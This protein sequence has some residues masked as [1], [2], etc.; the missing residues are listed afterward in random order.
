MIYDCHLHTSFSADCEVSPEIMIEQGIKNGL[1][2]ICMTDHQDEDF[3][4]EKVQF[5][6]DLPAYY[7][8]YQ[9]LQA[10]YEKDLELLF[11]VELG[12][13][14]HL[15]ENLASYVKSAPFDFVI[16]SIHLINR[17]DPW[18][19]DYFEGRDDHSA[20]TEYFEVA[21]ENVKSFQDFDAFGHLDYIIRYS[22][23]KN[24]NYSYATYRDFIDEILKILVHKGIGLELNTGSIKSG[25]DTPNPC[26]E[27]LLRYKEMGGEIITLGSDA[28]VPDYVGYH[29][30]DMQELLK[31]CGFRYFTTFK[32][33]KPRMHKLV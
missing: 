19:P 14:P 10:R 25:L 20:F 31:E 3:P 29:L 12:L 33:R 5:D 30:K 1:S 16:G 27:I 21:L 4:Y 22:P 17:V 8:K 23:N 9:E 7:K 15:K 2:G 28:H 18:Y 32:E 13:Q 6:L 24:K 26:K 11:G